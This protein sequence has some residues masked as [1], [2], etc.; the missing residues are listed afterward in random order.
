MR[1]RLIFQVLATIFSDSIVDYSDLY[2]KIGLENFRQ[3]CTISF[4]TGG[5]KKL[6]TEQDLP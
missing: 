5:L 1:W 3:K 4:K 2:R 6:F